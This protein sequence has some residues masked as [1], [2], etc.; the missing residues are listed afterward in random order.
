M[1]TNNQAKSTAKRALNPTW[2][3]DN[4]AVETC[5]VEDFELRW[6]AKAREYE[7]SLMIEYN[8]NFKYYQDKLEKFNEDKA[9]ALKVWNETFGIVS[10]NI[11]KSY[12]DVNDFQGGLKAIEDHFSGTDVEDHSNLIEHLTNLLFDPK[13]ESLEQFIHK[14]E[15]IWDQLEKM[16]N[17][18]SDQNKMSHVMS[19][20]KRST[21]DYDL[22]ISLAKKSKCT[23]R[24]LLKD[25]HV[26]EVELRSE[27]IRSNLENKDKNRKNDKKRSFEAVNNNTVNMNDKK[28]HK[29]GSSKH[30]IKD[31]PQLTKKEK[32]DWLARKNSKMAKKGQGLITNNQPNPNVNQNTNNNQQVSNDNSNNSNNSNNNSNKAPYESNRSNPSLVSMFRNNSINQNDNTNSN[33]SSNNNQVNNNSNQNQRNNLIYELDYLY[34]LEDT[35]HQEYEVINVTVASV[36]ESSDLSEI[37]K[38]E[39]ILDSGASAHMFTDK[40]FLKNLYQRK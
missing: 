23:L 4:I 16:G 12:T 14:F 36:T 37:S 21:K 7:R 5:T 2:T 22:E 27:R 30:F 38:K 31:C 33:N 13:K 19:A 3:A 8:K 11:A 29:C 15:V 24:A 20:V 6:R 32:D 39:I 25:L 17:P 28:C 40:L 35:D 26:K 10:Q 9:K 1:I 18:Q 34:E